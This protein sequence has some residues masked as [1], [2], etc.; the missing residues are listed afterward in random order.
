MSQ[1]LAFPTRSVLIHLVCPALLSQI[2][3]NPAPTS[4]LWHKFLLSLQQIFPFF[5]TWG[6][7][8]IPVGTWIR[9]LWF[10]ISLCNRGGQIE[11]SHGEKHENYENIPYSESYQHL[12]NPTEIDLFHTY[13]KDEYSSYIIVLFKTKTYI[14][15]QVLLFHGPESS[16]LFFLLFACHISDFI[17]FLVCVIGK[18]GVSL[19][20]LKFFIYRLYRY[21]LCIFFKNILYPYHVNNYNI[22]RYLV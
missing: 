17:H 3:P 14:R 16:S 2:A 22:A 4:V 15:T 8:L 12:Y 20:N 1:D 11:N 6:L 9:E 21:H 7:A 10:H 5:L 13:S 19:R 18:E